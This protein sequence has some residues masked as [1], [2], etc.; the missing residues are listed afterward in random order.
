[1]TDTM[2][3]KP[4][5][6]WVKVGD[7]K[8][9]QRSRAVVADVDGTD[10]AL[11]WNDGEPRAMYNI[12]V[13]RDRE[14]HRGMIFQGRV[15]CPGHQWGFDLDTGHCAERDRYQPVYPVEVVGDD[16]FVDPSAP[17]YPLPE[18]RST[19]K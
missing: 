5:E 18:P 12:C 4:G 3:E 13:H 8:T 2:S 15:I 6:P 10:I 19:A 9:L 16:I 7:T 11:F 14:L 17:S 1:M